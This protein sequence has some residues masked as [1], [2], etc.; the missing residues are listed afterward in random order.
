MVAQAFV[1]LLIGGCIE[2]KNEQKD[3]IEQKL[4]RAFSD[5]DTALLNPVEKIVIKCLDKF[6]TFG[7]LLTL[8]GKELQKENILSEKE[9]CILSPLDAQFLEEMGETINHALEYLPPTCG[10]SL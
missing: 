2:I 9:A 3:G 6:R 1:E 7:E 10:C 5:I 8:A 4:Y